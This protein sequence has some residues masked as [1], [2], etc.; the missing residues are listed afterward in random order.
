[1][2]YEKENRL[3]VMI[4][5]GGSKK[6]RQLFHFVAFILCFYTKKWVSLSTKNTFGAHCVTRWT[7]W[8]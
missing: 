6:G 7:M 8:K 1:M 5:M 4:Q 3:T 2:K